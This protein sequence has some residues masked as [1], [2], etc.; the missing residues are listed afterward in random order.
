M[1]NRLFQA[2]LVAALVTPTAA[3][4]QSISV[5]AARG[6]HPTAVLGPHVRYVLATDSADGSAII[7]DLA[8]PPVAFAGSIRIEGTVP[9]A[10]APERQPFA[11]TI[12]FEADGRAVLALA[13]AAG[14]PPML[15]EVTGSRVFPAGRINITAPRWPLSRV[16]LVTISPAD[17]YELVYRGTGLGERDR[18]RVDDRAGFVFL[19]DPTM[20]STTVAIGFGRNTRGRVQSD[21]ASILVPRSY[22]GQVANE[23]RTV[24]ALTLIV[25]PARDEDVARA[26]IVF[27]VGDSE[28]EAMRV[29]RL[30]SEEPTSPLR[31]APLRW[32]T[33]SAD[34]DLLVRQVFLAAGWALDWDALQ[35]ERS[36]PSS[37][38]RPVLNAQDADAGAIIALQRGDT[39]A[40]CGSYRLLRPTGDRPTR[41]E[42]ALRVTARGRVFAAA[43]TSD[44]ADDASLVLLG[45]SCYLATRNG[46][47][48]RQDYP[49]LR[50]A[51]SRAARAGGEAAAE[52]V[53]R[54]AELDD[55]LVRLS[56]GRAAEGDSLRAEAARIAGTSAAP[57]PGQL[58]RSV[59]A[60]AQRGIA[61]YGRLSAGGDLGGLSFG[62]AG[63]FVESMVGEV[64]GVTEYLDHLEIA[65][66]LGGIADDQ[67]WQ[68]DGLLLSGGDTLGLAYRPASRSAVVKLTAAQRHRI[69]LRFPWLAA[70]SCVMARRG[71]DS[72]RL[73]LV[74]QSDNSFYVDVRAAFDPATITLSA[75]PC[76][77][78]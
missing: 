60:D 50:A 54:L 74:Q 52:A 9:F 8:V 12:R 65:P 16:L 39:G 76:G 14:R 25:D 64:F 17:L 18:V 27:G 1:P 21:V 48:L 58:W 72:E 35:G 19:T 22:D 38:E 33:P 55:E 30:S 42:L 56:P 51:G 40:V 41:S 44:P 24:G 47:M 36:I 73:A 77:G 5:V 75:G 15:V 43:D 6:F 23:R 34:A 68:L 7:R 4:T 46:T 45:Y 66:Q 71:P 29:A 59:F 10:R 53:E 37:A 67:S 78:P 11:D 63:N 13:D 62:A 49:V 20:G 26:E 31:A 61:E 28:A 70:N 2:V 69:V 3:R 57:L 32:H